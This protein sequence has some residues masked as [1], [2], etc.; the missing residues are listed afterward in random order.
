MRWS[1][2]VSFA[3]VD[4]CLSLDHAGMS[5]DTVVLLWDDTEA[6]LVG[7][8]MV[9]ARL[10]VHAAE[11]LSGME[12]VCSATVH[13]SVEIDNF[14]LEKYAIMIFNEIV[15]VLIGTGPMLGVLFNIECSM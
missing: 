15:V 8:V 9:V 10:I 2:Y 6:V 3:V 13:G 12:M 14:L 4:E 7:E 5:G 1:D 11:R